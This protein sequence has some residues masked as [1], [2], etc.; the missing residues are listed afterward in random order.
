M[1]D[2]VQTG[3]MTVLAA[4]TTG[5][6]SWAAS[7]L[8]A[9]RKDINHKVDKVDCG[10]NMDGHCKRLDQLEQAVR[11]NTTDVAVIKDRLK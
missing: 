10:H 6:L 9:I 8:A 11:Q 7:T 2:S 4:L 5:V 3:I 1:T